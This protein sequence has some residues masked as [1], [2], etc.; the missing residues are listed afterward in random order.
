MKAAVAVA[1]VVALLALPLPC[2]AK[3]NTTRIEISR[4]GHLLVALEGK[5]TAGAFSIWNGP[6]TSAGP[7]G[8]LRPTGPSSHDFFD[9]QAGAVDPPRGVEPLTVHFHCEAPRTAPRDRA[10]SRLCYGVRYVPDPDGAGGYIQIPASRD[11][12]FP[13][14]TSI[15]HGVEGGWFRSTKRW[16]E[17][18]R[19][20]IDSALL[21][22]R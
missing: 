4:G 13:M 6:A 14:N 7:P 2:A 22:V 10:P 3:G 19:P 18:V 5:E 11:A 21:R 9:W 20:R 1:S 16:E 8:D 12:Q 15:A 17:I